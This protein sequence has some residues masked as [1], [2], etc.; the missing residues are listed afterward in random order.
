MIHTD[1][2]PASES[3]LV[4]ATDLLS[5]C[6]SALADVVK[7]APAQDVTKASEVAIKL[8]D[9]LSR[10]AVR[11]KLRASILQAATVLSGT[12]P[13]DTELGDWADGLNESETYGDRAAAFVSTHKALY[14]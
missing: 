10:E 7:T 4:K 1:K 13:E 8:H 9:Y 2:L 6:I 12:L 14:D 5:E 11:S 3:Q